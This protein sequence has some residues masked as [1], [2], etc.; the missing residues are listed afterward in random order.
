[1]GLDKFLVWVFLTGGPRNTCHSALPISDWKCFG[2]K[3]W[4]NVSTFSRV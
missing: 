1:V 2:S 4:S 3:Y